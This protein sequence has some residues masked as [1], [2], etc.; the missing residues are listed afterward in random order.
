MYLKDASGKVRID[1]VEGLRRFL[2][3][4]TLTAFFL[5]PKFS[6]GQELTQISIHPNESL[7]IHSAENVGFFSDLKNSGTLASYP[8]S[9][10]RFFGQRWTN[11]QGGRLADESLNGMSGQGGTFKFQSL[12]NSP[13]FI[14]NQNTQADQGFPILT[15]ANTA[16]VTLEGT[17]LHIKRNL[18]F[19]S[20]RLILNSRDAILGSKASITG[21]DENKFVVTGAGTT[22][23][24]LVR[25]SSGLQQPDLIFPIG[26][27]AGSYTPA[28]VNYKG[29]AQNIKLRVFENVFDKAT[30]GA[31]RNND[32]VSR[33]WHTAFELKDP[34]AVFS[35]IAQHSTNEEG[36]NFANN[37]L[38]SFKSRYSSMLGRWEKLADIGI[39]TGNLT[40]GI[41]LPNTFTSSRTTMTGISSEEYFSKGV[42]E[43]AGLSGLR[44]PVGISPNNDGLNEKFIIENL[45]PTDRVRLDIYNRWQTLVFRDGNY[46]NSFDGIGNQKGLINN[47]L[48]DGTY[49][50]ILNINADKPITGY[51]VINR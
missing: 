42:Q 13:Q 3:L 24:H 39:S 27:S 17:N 20:G 22:G 8:N 7:Y 1:K 45:Q 30:F 18:N 6:E 26:I 38:R 32:N 5:A 16:N 46:K 9:V 28:S 47:E 37:R 4:L 48:P 12:T 36:A 49:Y 29:L 43:S 51:I 31:Q 10:V 15:I 41:V 11:R 50:Y 14:E 2:F 21:F 35:I 44:I 25:Y 40:S 23:G 19:E 33:T 34:S